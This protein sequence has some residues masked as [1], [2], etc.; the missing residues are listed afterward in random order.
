MRTLSI[1]V[2]ALFLLVA[3]CALRAEDW[4]QWRGPR[5]D[6]ISHE[7]GL[8]DKWPEGGPK[9][10]WSIKV[11]TGFSSPIAVEGKV[12]AFAVVG[13]QEVLYALDAATGKTVWQQSFNAAWTS[14]Y[15]GSRSTP[16]IEG[17]R[18]YTYGGQSDL[19]CRELADG[20]PVWHMNVL[21]E[22]GGTPPQWG[23]ASSPLIDGDSLYVQGGFGTSA[24]VCI[25]KKT[26]KL[27]WKSE[28]Q[29]GSYTHPILI[30]PEGKKQLI[31][32]AKQA[33]VAMDPATGKTIWTQPWKTEYDVNATTPIY[34][35]GHLFITSGYN[36]GCMMLDVT[37]STATKAWENREISARFVAPVLDG[38]TLY[39]TTGND[40][41][42]KAISWP[43]GK[44][45]W[46]GGSD[47]KLGMGGAFVRVGDRLIGVSE[48]GKLLLIKATP[49]GAEKISAVDHFVEGN[50][51]W[52]TP[53]IYQGK[54]YLKGT[55][56]LVC[57]DISK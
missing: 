32:F 21:T 44:L 20:A 14:T 18:I 29:E 39:G 5:G 50:Q 16:T 27:I 57:A 17:N 3:T 37:A 45:K 6:G 36:R 38:D 30:D 48:R 22:I 31:I 13:E 51:I 28:A 25:D 34:R 2:A 15:G 8:A 46:K 19:I 11:G 33:V 49:E 43:D 10:V 41:I 12:Y 23:E 52:S 47:I 56:E 26:G 1:T 24:A 4:P 55:E 35:D 7:T 9:Q 53:L 40:G 54:L 42:L